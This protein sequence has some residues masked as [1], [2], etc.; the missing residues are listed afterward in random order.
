MGLLRSIFMVCQADTLELGKSDNK[1]NAPVIN[2]KQN[3][4]NYLPQKHLKETQLCQN[5][6]W[7]LFA[8]CLV[9]TGLAT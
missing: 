2:R 7:K 9:F 1:M 6:T 4:T 5:M 8:C 3:Y